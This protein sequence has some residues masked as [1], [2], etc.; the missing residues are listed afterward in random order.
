PAS[1][2]VTAD[3]TQTEI[4]KAQLG[5]FAY[6]STLPSA[7]ENAT[8]TIENEVVSLKI[9]NKGGYIVE[10]TIKG[11]EQFERNSKKDVQIIKNNNAQLNIVLNTKDHRVLNTKDLFFE[12]KITTEGQ[13]KVLTLQLKASENQFLEYRYVLKPNDYML[14]FGIKTQGLTNVIDTSKALDLEWQLK[15]FRNEKSISYENRYTEMVF[16]Y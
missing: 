6:S 10:A 1:V 11:M 8:T 2:V 3:A 16:E 13:N 7:Q 9:A 5:S 14:D 4:I 12:P 15:A